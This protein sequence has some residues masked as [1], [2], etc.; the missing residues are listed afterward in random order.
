M[1]AISPY[2]DVTQQVHV[3]ISNAAMIIFIKL[4]SYLHRGNSP[5]I[6]QFKLY[7]Q[8]VSQK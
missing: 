5:K 2:V 1:I 3:R 8:K 6:Q 4:Q 7:L